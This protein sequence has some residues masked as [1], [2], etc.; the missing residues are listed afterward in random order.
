MR[1][2]IAIIFLFELL[3]TIFAII[4]GYEL[5]NYHWMALFISGLVLIINEWR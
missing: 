3:L 5:R 2:A 4:G 1:L